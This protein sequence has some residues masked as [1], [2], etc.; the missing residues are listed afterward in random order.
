M[1][2]PLRPVRLVSTAA[3]LLVMAFLILQALGYGIGFFVDPASGVGEFASPPPDPVDELT[4]ALVG[5]VGVGMLGTAMLL[6]LAGFLVVRRN[7]AGPCITMV[8]GAV[9]VLAGISAWRSEW[10]W[11]AYFYGGGGAV[12]F[13]LSLLV[14]WLMRRDSPPGNVSSTPNSIQGGQP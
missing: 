2:T 5:Q 4:V 8:V 10:A 3:L 7:P 11:D 12:L 13:V 6:A 9:Y 14:W 1:S